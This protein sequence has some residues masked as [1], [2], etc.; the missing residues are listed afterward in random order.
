MTVF[1]ASGRKIAHGSVTTVDLPSP[2]VYV[3][4]A[5]YKGRVK[6]ETI[7]RQ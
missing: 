7:V 2:G 1:D 4:M 6:R 5:N 3:I